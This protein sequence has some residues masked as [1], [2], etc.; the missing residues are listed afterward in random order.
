MTVVTNCFAFVAILFFKFTSSDIPTG[1]YSETMDFTNQL[2]G[3]EAVD[4]QSFI[5]VESVN[6]VIDELERVFP[7]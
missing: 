5:F 2:L 6:L 7:S 4:T 3:A 1:Q